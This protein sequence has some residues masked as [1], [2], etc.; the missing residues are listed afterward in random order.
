MRVYVTGNCQ[1]VS[2]ASCLSVMA[3][4]ASVEQIAAAVDPA[5]FAADDDVVFRQRLPHVPWTLR[6][7]RANEI[8]YPRLWFNAF[9]P[10]LVYV[11][12]P[13]GAVRP[14]LGN[15]HSSLVL[16]A[17]HRRLSVAET[18]R[19]FT[20]AVFE[21][22]KFFTFW[23]AAKRAAFEEAHAAGFAMEAMFARWERSGCFMHSV[24]HPALTV[25]AG[26]ARGLA[27]R[28]GIAVCVDA[29]ERL[30]NDPLLR[31]AV[32][33]VY[34]AI[35]ARLG[36]PGNYAFKTP[37]LPG[38]TTATVLGLDEFI[39]RSFA[40]YAEMP[41]ELLHPAR[42]ERPAYRDLE[43]IGARERVRSNGRSP[44][45]GL[46]SFQY[47][48]RAFAGGDARDVDPVGTPP[49]SIG[50]DDRVA[51]AGSCFAEHISRA[52]VRHGHNFLVT[53]E[54]PPGAA[55]DDAASAGYG[56]FTTRSGNVYTARQLLQLFD[57][58]YGTFVP[59]DRAWLRPDRRFADPFRP[60]IERDGFATAGE[61][62]RS[63]DVHLTAVRAMFET[64]DVLV[65]TLGLTEAWRS[66]T[67]GAVFPLSPGVVA[68]AMDTA[69]YEFVN[70]TA[71]DVRDDL[72]GFLARLERVNRGAKVILSVSPVPL[73][74]TY[75][76]RHVLISTTYSKGALRA[77]ADEVARSHENVWYFPA[78]EIVASPSTGGAY[79][80]RDWRSVNAQGV[81]RVLQLFFAHCSAAGEAAHDA[82]P[83][84]LD[85]NRTG[86]DVLCDEA[87][88]AGG[89]ADWDDYRTLLALEVVDDPTG[90]S[91]SRTATLAMDALGAA[92][93]RAPL[94]AEVPATMT[95]RSIITVTCT[96]SN[97]GDAVL[98]TAGRYPVYLCYRWFDERDAPAE[99]G[100]AIHTP[101][102]API[103]AGGSASTAMR[104]LAPQRAGRYRLRVSLL[105]SQVAWFD[106]VDR[107][108]GIDITVD[109]LDAPL[110]ARGS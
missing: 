104:I 4:G 31:N 36:V 57:R 25:M 23:P 80:E 88:P 53:E 61:L 90:D 65:F 56:V 40:A 83:A 14:P 74:A 67:D 97:D 73:I 43:R 92:S 39:A 108:N 17:W 19:L 24:N 11:R 98:A 18:A 106:D 66:R 110:R 103:S 85:E 38:E 59:H 46:P 7:P 22:L 58:A 20:E 78:F 37:Q 54:A 75:E 48:R 68:G 50:R 107:A 72:E 29:P 26:I 71:A 28:A 64:L 62:L 93:M 100:N 81:R 13:A 32:W 79:Y 8:L 105:Q 2:L 5:G 76:P 96:V 15:Y 51:T 44:Y 70:F 42:L 34:P 91:D 87:E 101:L 84:M 30:V 109:V 89:D 27:D 21:H 9:H 95:A 6:A 35:A 45:A 52:L 82:D 1:A 10:D 86:A 102:P 55:R 3:P 16:Y 12:A 49:F 94:R 33:P 60:R 47:W 69:R 77:A 63:R 41:Q 99:L